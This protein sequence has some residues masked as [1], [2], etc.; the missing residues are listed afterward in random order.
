MLR[1]SKPFQSY[2][3]EHMIESSVVEADDGARLDL[4]YSL[5]CLLHY[6]N[7]TPLKVRHIKVLTYGQFFLCH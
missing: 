6:I 1:P 7:K 2:V 5:G 4:T 3:S